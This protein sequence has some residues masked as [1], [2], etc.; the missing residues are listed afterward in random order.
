MYRYTWQTLSGDFRNQ[1][2]DTATEMVEFIISGDK[3]R[4]LFAET[5]GVFSIIDL[6]AGKATKINFKK[7]LEASLE[8]L[9]S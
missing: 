4:T 1:D 5:K 7:V 2:Q 8:E 6:I 9:R 3:D